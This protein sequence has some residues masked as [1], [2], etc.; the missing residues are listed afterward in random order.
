M[1]QKFP[2]AQVAEWFEKHGYVIVKKEA[3]EALISLAQRSATS[4]ELEELGL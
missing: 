4:G 2:D 3:L 1:K